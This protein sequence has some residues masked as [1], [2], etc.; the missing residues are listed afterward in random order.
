MAKNI[1][2]FCFIFLAVLAVYFGSYLPY[3]KA[4]MYIGAVQASIAG[5]DQLKSVYDQVFSFYSPIGDEETVKFLLNSIDGWVANPAN[6]AN[7]PGLRELVNYIEPRIHQNDPRHL[8]MMGNIYGNIW[9]H[10]HKQED[11]MKAVSYFEKMSAIGP[12]L[13]HPLYSLL[14]LYIGADMP[15]ETRSVGERILRIWPED[16]GVQKIISSLPN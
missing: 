14:A 13:P 2:A 5:F 3:T 4:K 10:F 1:V 9:R 15:A 8:M 11:L 12:N 16:Q 7:E 6:A